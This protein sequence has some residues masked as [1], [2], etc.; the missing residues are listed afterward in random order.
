MLEHSVCVESFDDV[1]SVVV[2]KHISGSLHG[3]E[4]VCGLMCQNWTLMILRRE[5]FRRVEI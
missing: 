1:I 5:D 4:R 2:K 3:P